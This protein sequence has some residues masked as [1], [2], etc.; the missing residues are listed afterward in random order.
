[1]CTDLDE[2]SGFFGNKIITFKRCVFYSLK[3]FALHK[4]NYYSTFIHCTNSDFLIG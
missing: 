1:M 3:T 2:C 4:F